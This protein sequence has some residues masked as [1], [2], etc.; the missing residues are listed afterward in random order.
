[1]LIVAGRFDEKKALEFT[2]K[3]FGILKR[4]AR[5]LETTYTEEPAQDGERTVTLRRSGAVGAVGAVYHIPAGPHDDFAAL[6]VLGEVLLAEPAGRLYKSLVESKKATSVNGNVSACHDPG[7]LEILVQVEKGQSLEAARD[8][9]V[10]GLEKTSWEQI[11]NDE[12]ERAK[13]HLLKQ[14]ALMAT[15]T[16]GVGIALS[17]WAAQGDWR[18][19][20]IIRDRIAKV[21]TADVTRVARHY[22]VQNNRTLGLFIPTDNAVRADI[23]ATPAIADVIKNYKG[24][25]ALTAGEEFD[26]TPEA[27]EARVQRFVLAGGMKVALL[28]KKNRGATVV[29]AITLRYGNEE[30]L[31]GKAV[32]GEL[33]GNLMTRGTKQHNYQQF[34]DELDKLQA[35]LQGGS[36]AAGSRP[37]QIQFMLECK[38]DKLPQALGLLGEMLR[39][40]AFP[41]AELEI[42]RREIVTSLNQEKSDPQSL[43]LQAL[44]RKFNTYAKD[45]P[46][47]LPTLDEH[48]AS[49]QATT[50]GNV[51]GLY[52]SQ[53][54][55]QAGE[56]VLVGEFDPVAVRPILENLLKDWKSPVPYRH[57]ARRTPAHIVPSRED[58]LTPDKADAT[59]L[60]AQVIP[61]NVE[62]PDFPALRLAD[63][64][65]GGA[66]LSSRLADRV[67]QKDG[68]S[69]MVG[70]HLVVDA[71][72]LI[73]QHLIMARCNPKNIDKVDRAIAE[74]LGR[75]S[76]EGVSQ[77]E[78]IQAQK[79]FLQELKVG[80]SQDSRLASL[81]A[82]GLS[83]GRTLAFQG[84]IEKKIDGLT[85]EE[86][87]AAI[88]KHLKPEKFNIVRGGDFTKK[89]QK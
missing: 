68:L 61:M 71:R 26:P 66:G 7:V 19:F 34:Q 70:S 60:A 79:A 40:P 1:M 54:G 37:G 15:N 36:A 87:N 73:S 24:K 64:I 55:G 14:H 57:V 48:I 13:R 83:S 78:L 38:R 32:A 21:T 42:I 39:Q 69:Y 89:E 10:K 9:L 63:Y 51:R 16:R 75:F 31:K 43:A 62:D 47:Y 11:G 59:F 3:Y 72:D 58:I 88:R 30:S 46:R 6:E 81:L 53:V 85:V 82:E 33:L 86:V 4:P 23:P 49:L 22:L 76:K 44:R 56:I 5:T 41:E 77:S 74:E 17:D 45:D 35:R 84:A 52:D 80:R 2:S 67:R 18:L 65:L 8:E 12:V 29:A 27:I 28:P 50:V 25:S 20:F